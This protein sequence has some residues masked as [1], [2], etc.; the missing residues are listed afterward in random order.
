MGKAK[1]ATATAAT[2]FADTS[3][4]TWDLRL[5]VGQAI[6]VQTA[7]GVDLVRLTP[8]PAKPGRADQLGALVGDM[9]GL[10]EV[11]YAVV[12]TQAEAK[13]VESFGDFAGRFDL[14]TFA[15]AGAAFLN[16]F[17]IF[18][19]PPAQR[20]KALAVLARKDRLLA[21][22]F[23]AAGDKVVAALE[24]LEADEAPAGGA[25]AE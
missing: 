19:L 5:S 11:L 13:G 3:G 22:Q 18:Y 12:G 20:A 6:A 21:E 16:A 17:A 15:R 7:T 2:T 9:K 24:A 14:D 1:D 4:D 10:L 8:D 23:A 25:A